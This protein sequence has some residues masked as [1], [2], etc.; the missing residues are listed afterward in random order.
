MAL[1]VSVPVS[2]EVIEMS[3]DCRITGAYE[4]GVLMITIDTR[5]AIPPQHET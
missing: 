5:P 4:N 3:P 1:Y 2:T